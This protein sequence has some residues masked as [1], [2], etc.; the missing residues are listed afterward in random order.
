M[1]SRERRNSRGVSQ[2]PGMVA[3]LGVAAA[4]MAVAVSPLFGH[5]ASPTMVEYI[6]HACFR[7][8][9]S[10]GASVLIDPYASRVWLG[11]DFPDGVEADAVLITHPHYDHDAGQRR[12]RPFPWNDTVAVF[13]DP[14]TY[15]VGDIEIT[16]IEGKHADPYGME[17]GQKNTIFVI[18]VDGL[19]IAHIGD[20]GPLS[21]DNVRRMGRIDIL[22]LPVDAEYHILAEAEIQAILAAV[23]PR[24]LVPMHYRIGNLE[25][26]PESPS[27]LGPIDPW[28][29]AK[30]GVRRLNGNREAFD[31]EALGESM[32]IVVFEH[33]PRVPRAQ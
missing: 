25:T 10:T 12:G 32:Q 27:D 20:N 22:M 9:S 30:S 21:A 33:S 28:L 16:G 13:A 3:A 2:F 17:F 18:E 31:V 14:G 8:E 4:L 7:I 5:P 15:Q 23:Q 29:A 1:R 19:R 6:A 24:V 26:D 11:Y